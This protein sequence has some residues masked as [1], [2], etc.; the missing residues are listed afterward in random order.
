MIDTIRAYRLAADTGLARNSVIPAS[1]ARFT[2]CT[3]DR[4]VSMMTGT[5]EVRRIS[6]HTSVPLI[7]GSMR[8]RSTRSAP[9]AEKMR[10]PSVPR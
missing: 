6:R 5:L 10:R 8:S 1:L 2:A 9:W 3:S 7:P 4:P